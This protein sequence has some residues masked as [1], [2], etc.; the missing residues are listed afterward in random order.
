MAVMVL[1]MAIGLVH[2]GL[3]PLGLL[4]LSS[5]RVQRDIK[6]RS[7]VKISLSFR[8]RERQRRRRRRRREIQKLTRRQTREKQNLNFVDFFGIK[9]YF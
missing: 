8:R 5:F 2:F 3:F 7:G 1:T 6:C 9:N 4:L